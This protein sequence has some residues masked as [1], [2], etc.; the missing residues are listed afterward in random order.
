MNRGAGLDGDDPRLVLAQRL[1]SLRDEHWPGMKITQP[2]LAR[3]LGGSRPLSVPL[4]SSWES[5]TNPKI[6]P[7]KRIEAYAALF[8][9]PRSFTGAEPRLISP[10][11][12][13]E[14]ERQ[15]MSRLRSE[16]MGL[17]IRAMRALGVG[18]DMAP[19]DPWHFEDGGTVTVV[20]AQW[21]PDMLE[22]IPYTDMNDPDYI[23][24]LTYSDL[25]SLIMSYGHLRAANAASQVDYFR[26]G[27]LPPTSYTSHL[28]TL[29]G[30]DWNVVTDDLLG[31][32][33]LPV[34]QVADWG[35]DDGQYF[36]VHGESGKAQHRPLLQTVGGRKALRE[37]VALFAQ[38]VNPHNQDRVVTICSGMYGRGTYG[39]V[40]A[41]TDPE[42]RIRNTGYLESRFKNSLPYC[43]LTRIRVVNNQTLTPDWTDDN[44]RLFEWSGSV[45]AG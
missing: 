21:P 9:T 8:A 43:L 10:R 20:C 31:R 2:Q 13:S 27:L 41:L 25:D 40:R 7:Q 1:R 34:T 42:F 35:A 15:N 6:P 24:L 32:L 5:L 28:V 29:G 4:I 14:E 23:E 38:A 26:S 36:E 12:M 39:V 22:R 11:E 33:D 37:D 44:T 17:R 18:Q 3:A 19:R 45:D 30:A 16:L